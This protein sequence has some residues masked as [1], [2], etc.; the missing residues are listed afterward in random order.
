MNLQ[1]IKQM[2]ELAKSMDFGMN[3]T[4]SIHNIQSKEEAEQIA[5]EVRDMIGGSL[6]FHEEDDEKRSYQWFDIEAEI[7]N[8]YRFTVS[9]FF[10][11][12]ESEKEQHRSRE[13]S[14]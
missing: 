3:T 6:E 10:K 8:L 1:N 4:L 9:V 14:V 12:S 13:V 2:F 5:K 7:T 11:Y